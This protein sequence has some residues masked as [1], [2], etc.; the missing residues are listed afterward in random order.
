MPQAASVKGQHVDQELAEVIVDR[1]PRWKIDREIP[2][3]TAGAYEV[4]EGIK[5]AA[6]RMATESAMR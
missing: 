2:P 3:G 1:L 5:D 4:K 6:K